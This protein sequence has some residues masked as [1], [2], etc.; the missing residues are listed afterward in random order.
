MINLLRILPAIYILTLAGALPV[1]AQDTPTASPA[2]PKPIVSTLP[3][4][5]SSIN[6]Q[7]GD[8]T[9]S[10]AMAQDGKHCSF[11]QVLGDAQTGR[12]VISV[13]LRSTGADKVEGMLLTPFSLRLDAG[14]NLA[15]DDKALQGPIP[16]L[17]CVPEGCLVPLTFEGDVL[18]GLMAGTKL[19]LSAIPL[20]GAEPVKLAISLSGFT[21]ARSRTAELEK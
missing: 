20:S 14:V 1:L 2:A 19:Q 18:A 16:F 10:C 6:E 13:E 12:R 4:G 15:I 7:H 11:S 3:G 21:A 8:W 17:S 5:A 9:V